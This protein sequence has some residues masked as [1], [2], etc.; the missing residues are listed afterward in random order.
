MGA[1]GHSEMNRILWISFINAGFN[2]LS[3]IIA[4]FGVVLTIVAALGDHNFSTSIWWCGT[5][6]V[7]WFATFGIGKFLG[8]RSIRILKKIGIIK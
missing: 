6:I 5:A 4:F 8:F 3:R 7:L 1:P 2:F